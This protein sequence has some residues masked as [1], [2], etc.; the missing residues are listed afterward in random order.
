MNPAEYY[1]QILGQ[2]QGP[3]GI[4]Q[5]RVMA[6]SGHI[7]GT[8]L[9]RQEDTEYFMA[10]DVPGVFSQKEWVVA[11]ILSFVVGPLGVDRFYL[12]QVGLGVIKL[13]TCGGFGIWTLIDLILIAMNR[14]PDVDG[15]P[16]RK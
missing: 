11:L 14:L 2:E 6:R 7:Q 10:A 13:L 4:G 9:V 1:V 12:G 5:L 3:V 16:L 8:T 15:L